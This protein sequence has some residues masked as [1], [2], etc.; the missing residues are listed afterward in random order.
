MRAIGLFLLLLLLIAAV[1]FSMANR[2]LTSIGIWPLDVRQDMPLFLPILGAL[3]LG[4][5][6]GWIG[7]WRKSGQVRKQLRGAMRSHRDATVEIDRLKGELKQAQSTA[8]DVP[9]IAA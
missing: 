8:T 9:Q 4:F 3:A 7:A 5:I 6:G 1:F 2:E